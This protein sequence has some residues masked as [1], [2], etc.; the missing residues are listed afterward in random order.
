MNSLEHRLHAGLALSLIGLMILLGWAQ[1]SVMQQ[2]TESVV[3][4]RAEHDSQSLLASL[5]F[6]T[7]G[8]PNIERAR[9]AAVYSQPYSGHYYQI[10]IA[11]Q[12]KQ[13]RSRSLWDASLEFTTPI[14]GKAQTI[15]NLGPDEQSLLIHVASYQKQGYLVTIAI[16]EDITPL[17]QQERF[18][19]L[20]FIGLAI[21]ALLLIL[22]V[23]RIIVQFSFRPL[24]QVQREIKQLSE[25]QQGHL[26]E[27]V[28]DE[29][30]PLV[31][32]INHLLFLMSQ[33]LERSRNALGNLAHTLKGPLNLMMQMAHNDHIKRYPELHADL[34]EH[35]TRMQ[36]IINHE[37]KRA[38]LAGEGVPGQQFIPIEELPNL[39]KVLQRI[40]HNKSLSFDCQIDKGALSNTDRD[41]MLELLGNLLD[42]SCKWA[43]SNIR[44]TIITGRILSITIEDD[45]PGCT[46]EQID[47]ITQRGIRVDEGIQG[48]GLGLAI[49]KEIAQI[50]HFELHLD[51]SPTLGGLR[52]KLTS[53]SGK[54]KL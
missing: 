15:N 49:V 47:I 3:T 31:I 9:L 25:G 45:G 30:Q 18:Y 52:V 4:A 36:Q 51:Q 53:T 11:G 2:L 6:D 23:Q 13:L 46:S 27:A 32:E 34:Q 21:V 14:V 43:I 29:L 39:I 22:L 40:Y 20:V 16:A 38:R 37:L 48:H 8:T 19:T 42:N 12:D 54:N 41:D 10:L 35:T 26:T 33:R 17:Y 7:A 28:P 50:Y 5:Q 24:K 1:I 44:C